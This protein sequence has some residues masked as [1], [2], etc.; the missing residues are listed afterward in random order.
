MTAAIICNGDFPKKEFPRYLI[1]S[2]DFIICCDGA[3]KAY[4]R[5]MP[6]VFGGRKRLPDAIV[7]D[8]DSLSPVL[9]EEFSSRIV[10]YEEQDYNDQTK[11]VRYL[12]ETHPEVSEIHIL[13]ATGK[14]TDHTI[15]NVSLLMEYGRLFPEVKE[16]VLDMVS[17][18]ETMFPIWDTATISVGTGRKVSIFTPDNSL[19]IKSSGLE[20]S[21]EN[22]TFDNWWKATLN[23]A[24]ED[25][26]TLELSH[27]SM[28][29]L[30]LD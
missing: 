10:H 16:K 13:G 21:T 18:N 7:G 23:R 30:C 24:V 26:I 4:L 5:A 2:A 15:G 17:D 14:R 19:R 11:A 12:L 27:P 25:E 29:L 22:V 1:A 9:Q 8:M 3:L 28:V 20:Y 6:S